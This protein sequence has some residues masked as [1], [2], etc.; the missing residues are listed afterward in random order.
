MAALLASLEIFHKAGI[1]NLRQKS[2]KLTSYL[3]SLIKSELE[4]EIE[5]ITPVSP[6]S[7]GCQLSLRLLKS[8]EKT[9]KQ[10]HKRGVISDWREP[11][12]IR[13]APVPLYNSFEDC[14]NFVQIL[15]EILNE[16]K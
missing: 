11:D 3:E 1:K 12:I 5:I 9:T 7:R 16:Y 4:K 8:V 2:E 14:Y 15:K 6:Q 10:L 13:V